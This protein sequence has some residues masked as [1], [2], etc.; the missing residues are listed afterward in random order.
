MK[1]PSVILLGYMRSGKDS[2]AACLR[3][4]D[5]SMRQVSFAGA[6]KR[7]V[8][9]AL[10]A[11]RVLADP[12]YSEDFFNDDLNRP[13]FRPLLQWWGT[14]YR[15]AQKPYYWVEQVEK[16]LKSRTDVDSWACTDARFTNEIAMLKRQGFKSVELAMDVREVADYLQGKG[17]DRAQVESQLSHPSEREW[18]GVGKD[19]SFVSSFGNLPLLTARVVRFLS[20]VADDEGDL[21]EKIND[22][23]AGMYPETYGKPK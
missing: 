19:A 12:V 17:L 14:D 9:E 1:L 3:H 10:N 13:R 23:Y 6:L 22:F 4:L 21:Q 20:P 15:R 11:T 16:M 5:P 18:Q 7:E 8:A 2:V